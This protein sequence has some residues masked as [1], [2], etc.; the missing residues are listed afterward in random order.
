V[1]P[2]YTIVH[3]DL[4][5][6]YNP[7]V[8]R[9]GWFDGMPG[10]HD[11]RLESAVQILRDAGYSWDTDPVIRY[12]ATGTLEG[13]DAGGGLTMPNGEK[14]PDLEILAPGN[15]V[16]PYRA[17]YA[18]WTETWLSELGVPVTVVPAEFTTI[19]EA[20]FPPQTPETVQE[21]DMYVLGWGQI[22]PALPGSSQVVF[23][24]SR[25]D[26]VFG[27]GFNTSGFNN[28]DFDA[29]ADAFESAKT[30]EE[31]QRWTWEM[32]RIIQEE[33]PYVVLFRAA[34]VEAFHANV[35]FP[36]DV[37]MGGHSGSAFA[38]PGAVRLAE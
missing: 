38:W 10:T 25:E 33:L 23:F 14:V 4:T 7:D 20:V 26:V 22:S 15:E 34:I 32:E 3:P 31:A 37:I 8:S 19:I 12:D 36:S 21:W 18:S 5:L 9:P 17:A 2:G 16:D 6:W 1:F 24:H 27:G 11:Q 13:I 28:P 35:Q 30:V 29:A